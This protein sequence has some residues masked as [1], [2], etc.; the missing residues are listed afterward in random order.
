MIS[1]DQMVAFGLGFRFVQFLQTLFWWLSLWQRCLVVL[2]N[3]S[4]FRAAFAVVVIRKGKRYRDADG[5]SSRSVQDD[6]ISSGDLLV[7]SC[8]RSESGSS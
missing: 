4:I 8:L 2:L 1:A 3:Q 7:G 5:V 6:S